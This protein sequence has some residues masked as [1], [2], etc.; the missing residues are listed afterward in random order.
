VCAILTTPAQ[1]Q[2]KTDVVTLANGDRVT[3][4]IKN[5]TRGRLEYSTDD[6]GTIYFEWDKIATVQS[7]RQFEVVNSGGQRFLGTLGTGGVRLLIVTQTT[8]PVSL[9]MDEVTTIYEIGRSLWSRFDG[10]VDFGFSYTRSSEILQ[11]NLNASTLFRRPSSEIRANLSSTVTQTSDESGRDD[12]ASLQGS[13][14]RY[15]KPTWF[16]AA[17]AGLETNESLGLELRTQVA[18]SVGPKLV[19]TNHA[20]LWVSGGVAVNHE[21]GVDS[22]PT[23]NLEGLLVLRTSYYLYDRPKTNVDLGLQY[24][25]S[26]S[27]W[28]RHRI[29]FDG[30]AKREVWKDVFI[31]ANV[32]DTFDSRPPDPDADRNDVGVVLTFGLTY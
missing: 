19:N 23:E 27:D 30:G 24:Y 20:Q 26:L 17:G 4:E 9:P 8:G 29:Q 21:Q 12:R 2:P 11:L 16:F 14:L 13:Y 5:L 7:T 1:A 18:L 28:G 3:G 6:I 22:E 25:P 32:F 31:S 15:Y 10:S